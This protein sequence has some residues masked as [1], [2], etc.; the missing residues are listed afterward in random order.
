M[1]GG[2]L[3]VTAEERV[4]LISVGRGSGSVK[5][6]TLYRT[7]S[8]SQNQP[9]LKCQH[10]K[11]EKFSRSLVAEHIVAIYFVSSCQKHCSDCVL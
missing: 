7:S 11:V 10:A 2:V 4:L 1:F 8:I 6:A 5:H 9:D 3:D